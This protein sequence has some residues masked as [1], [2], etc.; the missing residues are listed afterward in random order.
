MDVICYLYLSSI[1]S[2]NIWDCPTSFFLD[3]FF[4]VLHKKLKEA[5][6]NLVINYK[7]QNAHMVIMLLHMKGY[8][9][10]IKRMWK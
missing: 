5:R 3:A 9:T 6:E 2:R 10:T 1:S 4:V 7:L 8:K